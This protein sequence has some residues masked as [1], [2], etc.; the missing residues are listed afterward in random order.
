MNRFIA[1]VGAI[2]AELIV[3]TCARCGPPERAAEAL[4]PPIRC[5]LTVREDGVLMKDGRPYRGIGVNYFDAFLRHLLDPNDTSYD[6]GFEKLGQA[7]IP[8]VR[9]AAGGFPWSQQKLY[10]ENAPEFF[11]RFDA[12]VKS[13]ERH[14]VGIVPSLFWWTFA[15]PDLVGEPV[16][17]WGNPHSK[18]HQYMRNYVRD[19]VTRYRNSPAIWGWEFGNEFNLHADLPNAADYRPPVA[20]QIG[21]PPSRS[22]KDDLTYEAIRTAFAAFAREVRKYDPHRVISTGDSFPRPS[23][24]HNWREKSWTADTQEQFAAMLRD[25]NPDP[26]S[27]I[28]VHAYE[29]PTGEH[30]NVKQVIGGAVEISRRLK[31]ALFVGEFGVFDAQNET[32]QFRTLLAAIEDAK[33]PLAALWV[34]DFDG[35]NRD[36]NITWTNKRSYQLQAIIEANARIRAALG[37]E[38]R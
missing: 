8:F 30:K 25:D 29:A 26:V 7:G 32:E 37:Q 27:V 19:V 23:A 10:Q 28:S 31:K 38:T 6:I 22:E 17:Q 24:W 36:W 21:A 33:V 3:A 14:N 2:G 18:T 11:R 9:I 13:A 5:G 1:I 34:Y 35:Q 15:V 16:N 4:A 12:V 20:P